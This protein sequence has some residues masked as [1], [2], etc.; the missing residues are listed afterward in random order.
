MIQ[1]SVAAMRHSDAAW[2]VIRA[3]ETED[4]TDR[5]Q[6]LRV[7]RNET[8]IALAAEGITD[9]RQLRNEALRRVPLIPRKKSDAWAS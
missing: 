2:A 5:D 1:P 8:L 9:A 3:H 6:E 7:A 4:D